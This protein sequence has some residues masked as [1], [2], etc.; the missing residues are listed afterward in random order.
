MVAPPPI[1]VQFLLTNKSVV[2]SLWLTFQRATLASG[3]EPQPHIT[4]LPLDAY[5]MIWHYLRPIY[6]VCAGI[7]CKALYSVHRHMYP[8]SI[9]LNMSGPG[10]QVRLAVLLWDYMRNG[11]YE[12][13]LELGRFMKKPLPTFIYVGKKG[14]VRCNFEADSPQGK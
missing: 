9:P 8:Y 11:D 14:W 7:T 6:Y 13:C 12:W 5:Y 3:E 10:R 1:S 2:F 4:T